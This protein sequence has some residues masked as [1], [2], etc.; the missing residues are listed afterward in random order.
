MRKKKLMK[1]SIICCILAASMA[2]SGTSAAAEGFSQGDMTWESEAA[3]ESELWDNDDEVYQSEEIE[4]EAE[5]EAEQPDLEQET[6][7]D[8][9]TEELDG[10]G[11][12]DTN[13]G[14]MDGETADDGET[15]EGELSALTEEEIEA[16]L[17]P[18]R[19]LEPISYVD[20]P[21]GADSDTGSVGGA[22]AASYPA[23]YDPRG[24]LAIPV[25]NQKP[26][27][28]CWAYTLASNL[29]I[30]FLRAGAGLFD[31]SEEH[32][33][34]FFANRQNDPLG[35]TPNDR[36]NVLHSYR[37]GG[38]QT[39]AAIFLS[40]WSGM[41]LE[42]QVPYETNEDHTLDSD[43]VPSSGM[44]YTTSAYLENAAFSSYS[45]QK[46]KNLIS[47][48]GSVSMSFG[49]YDSY[50]NPRT[51]AYSYPGS[52]GVNH[53]ITLVGWDDNFAKENFNSNCNVT[54]N[55]AWIVRNSWGNTWG[56]DGYFYLSYE[57]KCNYNIVAAEAVTSPKYKNNYFYDGSC[58][59]S[60]MKLY[61]SGSGGI[62]SIANVFQAK[63]GNGKGEALGEVVLSTYTDG[64]S[65][66]I[67]V[68]TNLKDS[69]DPVSGTP[70]YS[71]PVTFYQEHAG[72][73]TVTV[74]EVKLMNKTLYSVVITNI[75]SG[76]V[77]YLC[78]TNNAYS[79][80][81]FD[82]DLKAD[83]S[84]CYHD[85]NGWSDFAKTSPSACARIK[86]H[87]RTL[88]SEVSPGKPS[89][90]KAKAEAYNR[91][92]LTWKKVS[93]VSGYQI[94]RKE[95]G[96]KY[97]K[98]CTASWKDTSWTDKKVNPGISY[99]YKIRSY[100]MVSG[101]ARCSGFSGE[102]KAKTTLSVPVVTVK[103]SPDLYNTVNWKKIS[104]ASGY[105]VYRKTASGKWTKLTTVKK[106]SPITY[107]DKKISANTIYEYMVRAYRNVNGK[108]VTSS[109]KSSGKYKSAPARQTITSVS[110]EKKG[111]CLKWKAQ[112]KCDGYYI[113]RKIGTGKYKRVATIKKGSTSS[114]TDKKVAKGKKYR[115]YVCAYVKEPSGVVKS[116]YKASSLVRRTK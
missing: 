12:L 66:S 18:I 46:I 62:S 19:E 61:P 107:K 41:A 28:M 39:L 116:R 5:D 77:E 32:L 96:G 103:V 57:N 33:A 113:Y 97:K 7:S 25:R 3:Q 109:Y 34:Y 99:V 90:F 79:W 60:K 52:A 37:D 40:S 101:T 10:F 11:S 86:A 29:E 88:D 31:L 43:S 87:T 38:N 69:G 48:Y 73:S 112:K 89:S 106:S 85:K 20:P 35:N 83:Q 92:K 63:A 4:D 50:Y 95:A 45:V 65:Y 78:E 22:R 8:G 93:G 27:N 58:A 55:G 72:I 100:S 23:K 49:M 6:F 105:M 80:V 53:A 47:E 1:K 44:A 82:A 102:K 110:N 59:L 67:Q 26:S 13:Q 24:S 2:L 70:A 54:S 68:Y 30:S 104:G 71:T 115:Y 76:A 56:D 84:F 94:Y 15:S 21:K 81:E 91:V 9:K 14:F 42:A 98:V 64:G 16:Q 111:L 36:N 114:W 17:E 74:P 108:K 75:G 51:Y